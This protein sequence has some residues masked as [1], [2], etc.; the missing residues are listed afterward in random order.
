MDAR[1][2]F[3]LLVEELGEVMRDHGGAGTG[4]D[5][6]EWR[7]F[8][9]IQEVARHRPRFGPIARIEGRLAAAG[10]ALGESNLEAEVFQDI[11]HSEAHLGEKLIDDTGNE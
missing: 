3:G 8:E 2:S 6:D 1:Q 7:R 10:L 4:G 5:D 9:R 11:G